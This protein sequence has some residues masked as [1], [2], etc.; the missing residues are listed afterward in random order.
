MCYFDKFNINGM[1][2]TTTKGLSNSLFMFLES[3]FNFGQ[4]KLIFGGDEHFK[5][6]FYC[7]C[8]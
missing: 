3:I 6:N 2:S 1:Y 8:K 4:I 7:K 5:N